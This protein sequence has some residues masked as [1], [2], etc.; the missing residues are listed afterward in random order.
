MPLATSDIEA[1]GMPI[2]NF[3]TRTFFT[4]NMEHENANV[5]WGI[6]FW[7]GIESPCS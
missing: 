6:P 1:I 3:G 2:G 4:E 5:T 7:W